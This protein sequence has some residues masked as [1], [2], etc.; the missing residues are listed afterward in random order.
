MGGLGRGREGGGGQGKVM[1]L[2]ESRVGVNLYISFL[3]AM[4]VDMCTTKRNM[5]RRQA[6]PFCRLRIS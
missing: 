1:E 2:G 6:V 3:E 4:C 5:G